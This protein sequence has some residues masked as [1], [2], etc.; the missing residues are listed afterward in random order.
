MVEWGPRECG[1]IGGRMAV[2][3]WRAAV[4]AR[5]GRNDPL[6]LRKDIIIVTWKVR[7]LGALSKRTR[8]HARLKRLGVHIAILQETHMLEGDFATCAR[9]GEAC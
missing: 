5:Q 4:A 6:G 1:R 3:A 8:V 9:N 7:G 2:S